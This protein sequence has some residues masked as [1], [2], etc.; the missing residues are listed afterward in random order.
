[1]ILKEFEA[2]QLLQ[3]AGLVLPKS[4]LLDQNFSVSEMSSKLEQLTH[5]VFIKA[6]VLHG[7]R[8]LQGL[9]KSAYSVREAIEKLSEIFSKKDA[10][11]LPITECLVEEAVD[12]AGEPM[13]LSFQYSTDSRGLVVSYSM[14]GGVGMDYK[15]DTV[16]E[17]ELS[18]IDSP[19]VFPL[20]P[21]L[22]EIVQ[23]LHKIFTKSDLKLLE[24]NP[25]VKTDRGLVCLDAKFE[26]DDL[27]KYRHP[28]WDEYG[29]RTQTGKPPTAI[30]KKAKEISRSDSKGVAGESFFEFSGGDIGVL[31]SGGGASTLAMDALL[32]SGLQPANYTEYSGNPQKEKVYKLAELVLSLPNLRA[33]YVVGSNANFTD[34]YETLSGVVEAVLDAK[35]LPENFVILIRRGGPRWEEAFK[36]IE[37][38]LKDTH[39]KYALFGPETPILET[40]EK[41][42]QLLD[43]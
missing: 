18:I 32:L 42:K 15:G 2:K 6:Q 36:M 37:E 27:A 43:E 17:L 34:I 4:I 39:Y 29:V 21:E 1:M 10:F 22:L 30:E 31:A 7:N 13:Y 23:T 8:A 20:N 38:K 35:H 24:I 14:S 11:N 41:L 25:L 19:D 26:L 9:V 5:P 40:A 12:F 16:E 3:K 28:E 33:L